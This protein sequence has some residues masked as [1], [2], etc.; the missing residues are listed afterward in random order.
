MTVTFAKASVP[1]LGKLKS[2]PCAELNTMDPTINI[3]I[4]KQ[5]IFRQK[6]RNIKAEAMTQ[7]DLETEGKNGGTT[8]TTTT[9]KRGSVQGVNQ[10]R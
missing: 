2:L 1:G 9:K 6:W 7:N 5:H 8:E 4:D 10:N 3:S